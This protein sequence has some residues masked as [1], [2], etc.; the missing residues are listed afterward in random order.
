MG[1]GFTTPDDIAVR[2]GFDLAQRERAAFVSGRGPLR[3]LRSLI[4]L[5]EAH[6]SRG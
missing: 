4:S 5:A 3:S 1:Q 2:S 6:L